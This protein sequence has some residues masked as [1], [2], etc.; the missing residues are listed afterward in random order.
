MRFF[1]HRWRKWDELPHE[2]QA[3]ELRPYYEK[4]R[5]AWLSRF[6]KR[7]FDIILALFL[8]LLLLLPMLIIA[9][10][11]YL[12]DKGPVFYRQ[13]RVTRYKQ[14]FRIFK[15]R[16]MYV[17]ADRR[18]PLVTTAGDPRI[19]VTGSRLRNLRLDELPQLFNVLTGE[20]S[21]VGTRPE[22]R[23]Y[24]DAYTPEMLATLL[25]PAGITSSASIRYKDE[26]RLLDGLNTVEEVDR[27][28]I[29][30][31]LPA[32]MRYN[33]ED[34]QHFSLGRD[35]ALMLQTVLAVFR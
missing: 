5:K 32:K 19:T 24:V 22:V 2:M 26:N 23:K 35:M 15:F 27:R 6:F 20:M 29:E 1:P 16:T 31:V 3:Q 7:I 30:T 9:L 10:L 12:E 13:Q 33:L 17:D 11:I 25:M 21:F 8:C 4:L 28:Y 34:I 18:G 14:D